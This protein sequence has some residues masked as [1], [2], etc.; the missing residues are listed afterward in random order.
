MQRG[1]HYIL[2]LTDETQPDLPDVTGVPR[3]APTGSWTGLFQINE[4][5]V[6]LSPDTANAIREQFDGRSSQDVITQIRL[7]SQTPVR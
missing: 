5:G 7:C 2:F 1:E 6:H 4:S 3:I